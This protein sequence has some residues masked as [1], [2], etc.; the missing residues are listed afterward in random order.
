MTK[1]LSD[2]MRRFAHRAATG[3]IHGQSKQASVPFSVP[4]TLVGIS[5]QS[6]SANL[7]VIG[8]TVGKRGAP[9]EMGV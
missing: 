1:L 2:A 9:K 8:E 3:P 4:P 5:G 7:A 6:D